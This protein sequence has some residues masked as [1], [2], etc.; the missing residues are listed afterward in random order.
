MQKTVCNTQLK[1]G[2]NLGGDM[3]E[4][5]NRGAVVRSRRQILL[6]ATTGITAFGVGS[7]HGMTGTEDGVSRS[8][9]FIHQE[10]VFKANPKRV[11]EALTDAKQFEKVIQLS[12]AVQSGMALGKDPTQ[13]SR[14]AGGPFTL[15]FGHIVGRQIELLPNERIVQV[16]RVATWNPG[17]Y[18]I[19]KFELRDKGSSTKL[20]FDHVGFPDGQGQ[21]L[22]EGWKVNYWEPLEKYL[23]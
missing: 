2:V 5:I 12:A 15:F 21:H 23:I 3:N 7:L 17:V 22:A 10:P 6:A 16:W 8:A 1:A 4:E 11:Y 18:S 19:A 20:V 9:E 14:E 13:I